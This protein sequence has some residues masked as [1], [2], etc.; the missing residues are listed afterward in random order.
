MELEWSVDKGDEVVGY[1]RIIP[2][3]FIWHRW[4]KRCQNLIVCVFPS[5]CGLVFY[6]PEQ[7]IH[8]VTNMKFGEAGASLSLSLSLTHTHT[9]TKGKQ[10]SWEDNWV[11]MNG[12]DHA[13]GSGRINFHGKG[14]ADTCGNLCFEGPFTSSSKT[15]GVHWFCREN[16]WDHERVY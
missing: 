9:H 10:K 12:W 6:W 8:F 2:I 11:G 1:S 4:K 3:I 15:L 14:D 7:Q 16:F 5:L 13:W